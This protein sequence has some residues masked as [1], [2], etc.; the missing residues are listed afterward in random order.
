MAAE[1]KW[2]IQSLDGIT[3]DVQ[4]RAITVSET[5]KV[6]VDDGFMTQSRDIQLPIPSI[7]LR[8]VSDYCKYKRLAIDNPENKKKTLMFD[9][10]FGNIL[11]ESDKWRLLMLLHVSHIMYK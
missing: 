11:G 3:F 9:F 2:T 6:F 7:T 1:R 10:T 8:R 5:T 4:Q